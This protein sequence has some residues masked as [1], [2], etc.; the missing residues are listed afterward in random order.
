MNTGTR[1]T[2]ILRGLISLRCSRCR[3]RLEH[4]SIRTQTP[5]RKMRWSK[6]AQ[7]VG[8]S[9]WRQLDSSLSPHKLRP[10]RVL[11]PTAEIPRQHQGEVEG[12]AGGDNRRQRRLE[13]SLHERSPRIRCFLC[14]LRASERNRMLYVIVMDSHQFL[15]NSSFQR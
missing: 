13:L 5:I 8:V 1:C 3:R 11:L 7:R 2:N 9:T 6:G 12:G 4:Q 15:P 10:P 14:C